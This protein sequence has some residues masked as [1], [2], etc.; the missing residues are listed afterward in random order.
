MSRNAK[1]IMGGRKNHF[2]VST[3]RWWN[4][5]LQFLLL[6]FAQPWNMTRKTRWS[7][8]DDNYDEV[9]Q[10]SRKCVCCWVWVFWTDLEREV[11][12]WC[13]YFRLLL[14][15]PD[16]FV[17]IQSCFFDW[18]CWISAFCFWIWEATFWWKILLS[19]KVFSF[20]IWTRYVGRCFSEAFY[21]Y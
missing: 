6:H 11:D 10:V 12:D 4:N 16:Y 13:G 5:H 1:L 20:E 7:F 14:L 8:D 3:G 2:F 9:E 17:V 15:L 18:R 21:F 19:S